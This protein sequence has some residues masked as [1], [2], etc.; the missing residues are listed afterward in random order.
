MRKRKRLLAAVVLP[1]CWSLA[2]AAAPAATE[3]IPT[4]LQLR[5][6]DYER[7]APFSPPR[8]ILQVRYLGRTAYYVTPACCDIPSELLDDKGLLL[9]YAD[10][11][12]A[13]GDGRCPSFT[14]VGNVARTVW[15]DTR[16]P[17]AGAQPS[18]AARP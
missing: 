11:G 1:F 10:G 8:A 5:I 2:V 18:T 13:G 6:A 4:W 15:R 16:S 17:K 9:C 7:L 3:A 12:F 14:Q